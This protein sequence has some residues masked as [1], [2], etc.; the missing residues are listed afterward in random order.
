MNCKVDLHTHSIISQDGGIDRGGYDDI[1]NSGMLDCIAITDHNETKFAVEMA[2]KWGEKIIV[3]EEISTIE[4]EIIGLFLKNTIPPGKNALETA[5]MI[6]G[7]GGAVYI[8]HPFERLRDGMSQDVSRN[9]IDYI[10]VIEVFNGRSRWRG[11]T[12]EAM[13]FGRLNNKAGAASSDAHCK[14]GVGNTFSVIERMPKRNSLNNLLRNGLLEKRFAP[15]ASYICPSVN[16]L[17]HKF[18]HYG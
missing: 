8:P 16:R 14:T 11:K 18:I 5:K 3:G 7:Q 2:E 4:G 6:H 15:L 10:D 9:I 13:E 12:T 1:L 17:K